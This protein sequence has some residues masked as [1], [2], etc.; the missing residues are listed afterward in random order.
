MPVTQLTLPNQ[1]R[2]KK[3]HLALSKVLLIKVAGPLLSESS[4]DLLL[5]SFA[6]ETG[7]LACL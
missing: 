2:D 5:V 6:V 1:S 3:K 7:A 4:S